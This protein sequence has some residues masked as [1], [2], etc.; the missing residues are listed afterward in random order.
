MHIRHFCE[1]CLE[2][3]K[4]DTHHIYS[5]SFGGKDIAWNRCKVCPNCHRKIH[6]G[7]IIIEGRFA[8]TSNAGY[9]VVWRNKGEESITGFKDPLVWLYPD[10]TTPIIVDPV[11]TESIEERRGQLYYL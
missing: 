6:M 2:N 4:L 10:C 7:E 3:L 9:S 5:T 8:S 11:I 1:I